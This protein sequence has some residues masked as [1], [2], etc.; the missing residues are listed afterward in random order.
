[1]TGTQGIRAEEKGI[2][3]IQQKVVAAL[4][5]KSSYPH[6]VSKKL[7]LKKPIFHGYS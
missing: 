4:Q 5:A 2:N 1:M 7:N 3:P 6:K